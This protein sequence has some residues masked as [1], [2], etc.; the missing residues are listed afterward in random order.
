MAKIFP[1]SAL[2]Y[3]LNKVN[4]EDVVTQP[5]DKITPEMQ[6]KYYSRSPYN[7][8]R[9]ILGKAEPGDDANTNVY[10]RAAANLKKWREEQVLVQDAES[11]IYYYSQEFVVPSGTATRT[12]SG[13]IAT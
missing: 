9:V 10:S 13:F 4:A 8:V 12:R 5:Y 3:N 2:R 11:S 6:E 7:L 1:F